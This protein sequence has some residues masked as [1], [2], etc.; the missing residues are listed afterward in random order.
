LK[1]KHYDVIIEYALGKEIQCYSEQTKQWVDAYRPSF[2]DHVQYR[3]KPEPKPDIVKYVV[4][5]YPLDGKWVESRLP[6][7][8]DCIKITIDG[9][10]NKL[11]SAEVYVL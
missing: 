9:E 4:C 1:H 2:L 6:H 3:V 5:N 10:T 7:L 11:K 8:H